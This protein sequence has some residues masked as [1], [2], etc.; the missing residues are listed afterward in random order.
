M[1]NGGFHNGFL[2][3]FWSHYQIY[4]YFYAMKRIFILSFLLILSVQGINAGSPPPDT[5]ELTRELM[6]F[7]GNIHQ[8]NNIF[9]QE[10]VYIEFDN[11]AYFQGETIWFKAFVTHA[12]TLKRAP[13]KVLYV[14]LVAPT[15]HLISQQKLKVV[16]GQCDGAFPLVD[17]ATA[18]AREKRGIVD[19]PSGFYEIRAYTQ[20]MLDFSPEAVFSRVIPVY[21]KPKHIGEYDE[22]YVILENENPLVRTIRQEAD[23]D[24]HRINLSFYP[25]GGDLI[26]GLPCNVAF[27][28]TAKDGMPI[29]GTVII[30][31]SKDTAYTVHEGMGAFVITPK[32]S[33]SVRFIS[34]DGK[35]SRFSIPRAMKSGY[36]MTVSEY[37]D[38]LLEVD[39]LHTP[40][41]NGQTTGLAV[42]CRGELI[43]FQENRDTT[44]NPVTIDCSSWPIGVCRMTL[45]DKNGMILSSRSLFHNNSR[46]SS[47]SITL[48]TDS[49]SRQPFSKE[50][51]SLKLTDKDGNP[52]RDRFCLSVRDA[53]DY[54]NGHTD[55]LH[56]NLLLSSDLKGF[57]H[58][59]AWYLESNDSLHREALNLL[60][61]VQGW[62][63]YEWKYMT[64]QDLFAEKHRIEDSLT[65]NGWVLSY[66]RRKPV[67]DVDVYASV[68]PTNDKSQFE[69]FQYHTDTTGY[70]GF[71]LSDFYGEAKMTISLMTH[72]RNGKSKFE[73]GTRI[74]FERSDMP[75]SRSFLKQEIDLS[76][77]DRKVIDPSAG[78]KE[79]DDG[80]PLVIREDLGIVLD[81]VDITEKRQFV[82]YDTFTAWDAAK[83]SE[84][85]L[86]MGEY[87]TDVMGYFLEKG[88]RFEEYP[89]YFYVHD[90]QKVLDKKPFDDPMSIDMI[91]VKSII[92]YDDGMYPKH[93]VQFA[94][95]LMDFH[96]K[97]LD[98]DWFV[99]VETNWDK[100]RLVD[101]LIKNERDLLSYKD[102]RNLSRRTTTVA[103]FSL[104]VEFYS[105]Q[106]PEGPVLGDIDARRTIYWNPNV[107]TDK[108]GNARVEFYNNS[109]SRKYT[110]RGAGITASGTPY[111][112]NQTW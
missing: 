73:T 96:R 69:S 87:T 51:L 22:S 58:D 94:P 37:S 101:I 67:K 89:P 24:D 25:E 14:D 2:R 92:V 48:S 59:P 84:M 38:S 53:S 55:N 31:G 35:S 107:I 86:D 105:P 39:I 66:S 54:G 17:A 80:L 112:L 104:P 93:F 65:M 110:I 13:S 83:E 111:I 95:L 77:H 29:D 28:A 63:R 21:T 23:E 5:D 42:T 64:G 57:I 41:L 40:D 82:D 32:G 71:D 103:G 102:I 100:Y 45:Y 99:W 1:N 61:L 46:F 79:E 98:T 11:T 8:F 76:N 26:E 81:D 4:A 49:M 7:S 108:D 33:E 78:R 36:S 19:Y 18:Q 75:E 68:I 62:E 47:P 44:S 90:A 9:P 109:Y 6:R 3:Y 106:Y 12:T 10:K 56:T 60:T 91:Y 97:H 34:Q 85:E 52:L 15:G 74:R 72:K 43:H 88:I 70:F 27:K 50:I 20:N 30:S 16:A